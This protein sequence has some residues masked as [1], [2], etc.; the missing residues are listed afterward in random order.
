MCTFY[1]IKTHRGNLAVCASTISL[2]HNLYLL[3]SLL[4]RTLKQY[5]NNFLVPLQHSV[6]FEG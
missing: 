5:V 4:A 2:T 1:Y 3:I 6:K